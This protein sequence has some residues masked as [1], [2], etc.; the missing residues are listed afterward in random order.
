MRR[1][2]T[3]FLFLLAL[4][5]LLACRSSEPYQA[6]LSTA[7]FTPDGRAIVFGLANG[8]N[9]YLYKAEIATGTTN[10]LTRATSGCETD[11]AF[12]SDGELLA[13]MYSMRPG[14]HAALMVAKADGTGARELVSNKEDN[15]SPVFVPHSNKIVFLRSGAFEHHS[16]LVDNSRHKFDLFAA[17][18][19]T[20]GVTQLTHE[21]FYEISHVSAAADGKQLLISLFT[22]NG[23][24]FRILPVN[25]PKSQPKN[26]QPSVPNGPK[27]TGEDYNGIWL[28]D[29]A[30]ILFSGASEPPGGGN[31]NYNI[32]RTSTTGGAIEQLTD[33]TGLMEG[34]SVSLDA[35]KA[36][37]L[38]Q[39]TY[40]LLDLD[41]KKLNPI[42]VKLP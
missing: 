36:V 28:P 42:P 4:N 15:L 19:T 16:P 25:D 41:N 34:F 39:G 20:G 8:Q 32:Y 11:P 33:L 5:C 13:Y 21:Q 40:S 26:L 9:C 12:S 6:P 23:G 7:V 27:P 2:L 38:R 31:F 29:G 24:G 17:D 18:L 3:F 1:H 35:K 22:Q 30:S 14:A 10:R 37:V